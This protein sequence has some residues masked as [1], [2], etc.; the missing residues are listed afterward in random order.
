MQNIKIEFVDKLSET[1]EAK[2]REGFEEYESS[3]GI[4]VNYKTFSLILND[5]TGEVVAVLNAYT[6][7]AE[8]YIDDIWVD[9]AHRGKGYGKQ[10]MLAL[11]NRFKGQG[12]NNMNLVTNAFQAPGFYEKCGFTPE[13]VRENKINPKLT[14]TFFIKYFADEVQMQGIKSGKS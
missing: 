12:Y 1:I 6:V 9:K 10:L 7:F 4:D 3:K 2:M 13:F 14:K 5:E 11:E 8:I